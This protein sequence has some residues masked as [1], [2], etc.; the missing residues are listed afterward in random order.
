MLRVW[1]RGSTS[2]AERKSLLSNSQKYINSK[3][4][5]DMKKNIYVKPE[6]L[7]VNV[8]AETLMAASG[9]DTVSVAFG[10]E[11]VGTGWS[12]DAKGHSFNVWGDDE[13]E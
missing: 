4:T 12:V 1:L 9:L 6:I 10:D 5:N 13:E 11:T 8:E 7:V 3:K 2:L